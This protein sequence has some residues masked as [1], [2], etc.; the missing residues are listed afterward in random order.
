MNDS[1]ALG[2]IFLMKP[3]LIFSSDSSRIDAGESLA[4]LKEEGVAPNVFTQAGVT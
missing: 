3:F 2:Y 4:S 1:N